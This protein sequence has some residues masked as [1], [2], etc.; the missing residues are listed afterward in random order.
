VTNSTADAEHPALAGA[1]TYEPDSTRVTEPTRL[2]ALAEVTTDVLDVRALASAVDD[3]AAGAVVTFAGVVRD[4]DRGRE[5]Q[6]IEYVAHPT[7]ERIIAEVAAE[8]VASAP[9]DALAVSHRVGELAVGDCAL[10]VA[11][12]AAHRREAFDAASEVVEQVKHR[13][14]VWKRQVFA[15]GSDE[16]VSCP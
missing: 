9:V 2:V 1:G 13:L 3:P 11:V 5:V 4:H 15:D 12:S 6:C 8:I 16:W 10:A 14:P 7:A